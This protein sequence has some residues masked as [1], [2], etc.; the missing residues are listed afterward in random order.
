MPGIIDTDV[1]HEIN[2]QVAIIDTEEEIFIAKGEPLCVYI[3][4]KRGKEK[5]VVRPY[6]KK[7]I[8][9]FTAS[10]FK[11]ISKANHA[12]LDLPRAND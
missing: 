6:T 2:Q 11:L 4:F 9:R 3:P 7:D 10:R 5:Y 8:K 12:Y 1:H